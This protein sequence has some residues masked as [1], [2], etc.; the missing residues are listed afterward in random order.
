MTDGSE[1]QGDGAPT[2]TVVVI[3]YNSG[4][5]ITSTIA[6]LEAALSD[7]DAEIVVV[8]NASEDDTVEL[9][10]SS[11]HGGRVIAND[12]NWGYAKAANVGLRHARGA[13]TL[14]MNDDA[15]LDS[16]TVGRLIEVHQSDSRIG[17]VGPRIVDA[18]GNPTHS[19]RLAYPGPAEEWMRLGDIATRRSQ[20]TDYPAE[21][22]PMVV[23]WLIAACV[24]GN[25][26]QLRQVGGFNEEFFLYGEDID[27][28]RRLSAL[29]LSSVTVPD[30]VCVHIG[31]VS[32]EKTHTAD[33]RT[34][35]QVK[36]RSTYYRLWL[37]RLARSMVYLRRAIGVHGQPERLR[38]FLPLVLWD[39]PS[40]HHKRFPPP[41]TSA[42]G[43]GPPPSERAE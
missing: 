14:I 43:A 10:R 27:L 8:D 13:Y 22:K 12:G 3:T 36:G 30:A 29:G 32:T 15:Q 39:G 25:T 6:S 26:E 38:M 19:A 4:D 5:S 42:L 23:K 31:G 7:I 33:A 2:V 17:L 20:G 28:G 37:P 9:A 16:Q 1:S 21:S 18:E 35:R 24:L 40:L 34:R 11:M 41:L